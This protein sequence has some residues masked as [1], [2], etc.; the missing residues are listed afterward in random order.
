MTGPLRIGVLST[1]RIVRQAM[2]EAAGEVPEVRIV[3][4]A[5]RD[6]ARAA[7]FAQAHGIP[8][9]H[10]GYA[11]LLDDP[12]V[13]VVYNPLPN[14]LHAYWSIAAI[15]A[16]KAVLCEKPLASNAAEAR[17]MADA[18][19]RTGSPLIEAFHYRH[20]PMALSIARRL[21][22]GAVGELLEVRA[23]MKVPRRLL[24]DDDIRFDP[25]LAGGAAMDLGVYGVNIL[26]AMTDE[27]PRVTAA[28]AT[29]LAAPDVDGAMEA[30]LAFPSGAA[31]AISCSLV[32]DALVA[33][34][35]VRGTRGE[36][37]A[38]NPF[39]PQLG[40]R[41]TTTAEGVATV[42]RFPRTATY[43]HQLRALARTLREGA[44]TP[45]TA[46]DGVRTMAVIDD[47]YR[48]SGL[49]VR[50]APV[51]AEPAQ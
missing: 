29:I 10:D 14:S 34:L 38:E 51:P 27:E 41:L 36:L 26:R 15:E 49:G 45:T 43:V 11:D 24:A 40:N 8:R 33:R 23:E 35:T 42:T 48:L 19:A 21:R 6:R 2:I 47:I 13:E 12:E 28:R 31:G 44:P 17:R 18:A 22:E 46:E 20:H 50:R 5:S 25:S 9:V 7:A 37:V 1:A 3:A 4:V 16:G 30:T 39:L 32:H